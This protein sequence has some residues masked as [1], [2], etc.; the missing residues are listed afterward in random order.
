MSYSH[1]YN[2]K[3]YTSYIEV[4]PIGSNFDWAGGHIIYYAHKL[5]SFAYLNILLCLQHIKLD[6]VSSYKTAQ[7]HPPDF[8]VFLS[9]ICRTIS[10]NTS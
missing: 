7:Q 4:T 5:H 3:L 8:L 1:I 6:L 2:S 9:H 10:E